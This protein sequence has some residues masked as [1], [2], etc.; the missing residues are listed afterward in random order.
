M[1]SYNLKKFIMLEDGSIID[2]TL[3]FLQPHIECYLKRND[4]L[5]IE[6]LNGSELCIGH[7]ISEANTR[8]GLNIG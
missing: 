1:A 8:E 2:T 7:I 4:C 6:Y 5:Y 3:T